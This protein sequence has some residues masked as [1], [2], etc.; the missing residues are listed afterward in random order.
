MRA[1]HNIARIQFFWHTSPTHLRHGPVAQ[2]VERAHGMREV[3][4]SSLLRSTINLKDPMRTPE[5][6]GSFDL[7]TLK[8]S[9]G[10]SEEVRR[11]RRGPRAHIFREACDRKIVTCGRASSGPQMTDPEANSFWVV[12]ILRPEEARTEAWQSPTER[13]GVGRPSGGRANEIFQE[14][15]S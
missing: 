10:R 6:L 2:L 12:V 4:S 15:C 8:G 5:A 9:K 1:I 13:S 3:R 11:A 14:L 7:W